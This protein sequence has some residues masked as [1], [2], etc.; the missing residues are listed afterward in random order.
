VYKHYTS[1]DYSREY[2]TSSTTHLLRFLRNCEAHPPPQ[3][4]MAQAVLVT[5]GGM[6]RY[7]VG[8]CFPQLAMTV[9]GALLKARWGNR[10]NLA[11][12]L[13][14]G[15]SGVGHSSAGSPSVPPQ[16]LS[17]ELGSVPIREW[18]VSVNP[19]LEMYA[20]AFQEYGYNDTAL[21]SEATQEDIQDAIE[22][23]GIKKGHRRA[24]LNAAAALASNS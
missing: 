16:L 6:A 17:V 12:W 5:H 3:D 2:D 8:E 23:I 10:S 9:R 11:P 24:L 15:G 19:H 21:L 18:L 13:S 22:E 4:S 20:A 14:T 1:G 7:F